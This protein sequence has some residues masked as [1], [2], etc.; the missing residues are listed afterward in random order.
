[1]GASGGAGGGVAVK[2]VTGLT[3]GGTVAVTIGVGGAGGTAGTGTSGGSSSFGTSATATGGA[4][5]AA[6]NTGA[7]AAS[8]SGGTGSSGD[9]NITGGK[10]LGFSSVVTVSCIEYRMS[11]AGGGSVGQDSSIQSALAGLGYASNTVLIPSG[12]TG[13]VGGAGGNGQIS[14][15]GPTLGVV[16]NA[17]TGYGNGG[18]GGTRTSGGTAASAVGGAGSAGIVIVEW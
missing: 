13:Y 16:G 17:A 11:G 9:I 6:N 8:S 10:G 3:P 7:P 1:V 4:G 14:A 5:G 12:G 2:F 18:G 15:A